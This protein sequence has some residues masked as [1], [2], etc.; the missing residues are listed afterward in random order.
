ME[1][2]QYKFNESTLTVE[3]GNILNSHADVIVSSDDCY[4]SMGGGVSQAILC[5]GGEGIIKDAR[6]FC[7][8]SLGDVVVTS[9]G[10]LKYQ[11]YVFHC[12]TIDR[13]RRMQILSEQVTEED[14][15]NYI[16]QHAVDK[17]FQLM[18]AMEISSIAFPAIGAGV[19]RIPIQKVIEQ[20]SIAIARN[21]SNTNK[22]LN[23]ELYLY[24]I[25]NLYSILFSEIIA[26]GLPIQIWKL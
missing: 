12:I 24:D 25:Y 16:L 18:Q 23:I 21:L 17:C 2:R 19:A 5:A 15:L 26:T 22:K 13:K 11:K 1:S 14:I 9:A 3:F 20:M 8:V 7:L 10:N 6:K 4:I